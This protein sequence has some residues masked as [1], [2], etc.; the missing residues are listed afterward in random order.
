MESIEMFDR[1]LLQL[2]RYK[3]NPKTLQTFAA[4]GQ[5]KMRQNG[6]PKTGRFRTK[7]AGLIQT[8]RFCPK[9]AGFHRLGPKTGEMGFPTGFLGRFW[10]VALL[11][12]RSDR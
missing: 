9:P 3:Y 11:T 12:G 6:V 1:N 10:P 8:G 4:H 7:P 5:H 2:S